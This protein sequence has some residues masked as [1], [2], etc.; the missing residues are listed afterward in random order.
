MAIV[1]CENQHY[2]DDEKFPQCPHCAMQAKKG[3]AGQESVTVALAR[4]SREVENYAI[5]YIKKSS[6]KVHVHAEPAWEQQ[7]DAGVKEQQGNTRCVAGWLVCIEGEEYGCGFPLYAGFNRIGRADGN[8]IILKDPQAS[9]E[10]H[11]SVIYEERKNVFYLFPKDGNLTYL[12][13]ELAGQAQEIRH[14]QIIT[15]G[16]T[17]LQFVAFCMGETRWERNR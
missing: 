14:G 15:I 16:G 6:P 4:E 10:E 9:R 2:Y 3:D 7:E 8:D 13:E 11:C 5:E 17:R 1:Q 12:G